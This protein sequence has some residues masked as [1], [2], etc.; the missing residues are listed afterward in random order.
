MRILSKRRQLCKAKTIFGSCHLNN[1]LITQQI[2]AKKGDS[3]N[4]SNIDPNITVFTKRFCHINHLCKNWGWFLLLGLAFIVLGIGAIATSTAVT[5]ASMI[6]LGSLLLIGGVIQIAYAFW[7]HEWSGFFLSLLAGILYTITGFLLI[8]HPTVGALSLTLLLA[9]FFIVG[10]LFRIIGSLMMRFEQWG[11]ALFSG[12]VELILGLLIWQGWPATGFW[13]FGLFIG[14]DLLFYG[15]F[16]VLL[17][18]TA[19]KRA[20]LLG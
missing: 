1:Y 16:W 5:L 3:M 8:A 4:N 9:A 12:I 15:W 17:S 19:K 13:V 2:R 20:D 11:W 10:G 7:T 18:L 14:I 6:V